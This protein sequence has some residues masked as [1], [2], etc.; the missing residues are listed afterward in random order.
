MTKTRIYLCGP[1]AGCSDAEAHDWRDWVKEQVEDKWIDDKGVNTKIGD[2]PP[3]AGAK[4][5]AGWAECLDPMRRDYRGA[6]LADKNERGMPDWVVKEIVELDKIDIQ[7]SNVLLGDL[8]SNKKMVGSNMEVIYAWTIG[9]LVVLVLPKGAPVSPW[10][11]Y[12]SH[13]IVNTLQEA[14]DYIHHGNWRREKVFA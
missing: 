12:H 3:N 8:S 1:I 5:Y 13:K 10:H 7:E 6:G 14:L 11:K 2:Y 4:F 9:K